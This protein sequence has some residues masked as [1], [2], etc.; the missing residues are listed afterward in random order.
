MQNIIFL[1]N[2]TIGRVTVRIKSGHF[3]AFYF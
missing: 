2:V 1:R 3:L